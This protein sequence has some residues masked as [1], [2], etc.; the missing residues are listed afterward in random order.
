M[1]VEISAIV[2]CLTATTCAVILASSATAE[3]WHV[4]DLGVPITAVTYANS[5]AV[6]APGPG[7]EGVM[8]YT[9]YYCNTGAELVGYDFRRKVS[10]RRKLPS[11][12]GYGLTVGED[13]GVYIGGVAPGNLHRYDP[14]TDTLTT[15]DVKQFGVQYIWDAETAKGGVVYCAAGYPES[16]LVAF[17]PKNGELRDLGEMVPGQKY[18][19][20]LCVDSH[21]KVWCG[22]GSRA[23]LIVCDPADGTKRDV[24]P[25]AYADNSTVYDVE[26]VGRYVIAT[27]LY[28]GVLLVYDAATQEVVREIP[29]PPGDLS[30]SIAGG[31]AA[32]KVYLG[33][34]P[35]QDVYRCDLRDG[36]LTRV[37]EGLG[38]IKLVEADRW[39]HVINDQSY[40]VYDLEAKRLVTNERLTEGGDGMNIFALT[41]GPDGNIYGS[42]YINMH[43]FRCDAASGALTDLGKASRW[44]GQV[45]SLSLGTDGRIYIGA[46]VHA[47]MSVY[48][49]ALPW[50]PG[51]EPDSNPREI[52]PLGEGQ[53][54]TKTNCLGSD[55]KIYVGSIPSYNSAPTGAF[56][57]CDPK[58]GDADVR[59][60]FVRGGTVHALAADDKFVYGA[61]GGEFFAYD[62][63]TGEKRFR[64][65]RPVTALAVMKGSKVVGSGNGKLFVYDRS[66]NEITNDAPNPAGD[67]SAMA[68][69]PDGLAYGVNAER[70]ARVGEDGT[71]VTILANEGGQFAALDGQGLIYFARGP[72]LFRCSPE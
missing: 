68:T 10:L 39:L 32:D 46:Y 62:P 8:F 28:D 30:W 41:R 1:S 35:S 59:L 58:T 7:G 47:L 34:F 43:L 61:G 12:G 20:E 53:Y 71:S 37:A 31:N 14:R 29:S 13:G 65:E 11:Q 70:V 49:P 19:R 5:S 45:D 72:R 27:V 54:R 33:T 25:K 57:I 38:Q 48:D 2:L 23:H 40:V 22:I 17:D 51:R 44:Q 16:K 18:L 66:I 42:T 36:S 60:D 55:G 63:A 15:L 56:T 3:T 69:G 21:G 24:L 6:L 9:S 64:V 4:E 52:G 67:F 50:R 26:S